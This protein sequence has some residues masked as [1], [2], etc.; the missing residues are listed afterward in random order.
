MGKKQK[1]R[2]NKAQ[3]PKAHK[4][5]KVHSSTEN[6]TSEKQEPTGHSTSLIKKLLSPGVII[7]ILGVTVAVVSIVISICQTKEAEEREI[8]NLR[9][10]LIINPIGLQD[11]DTAFRWEVLLSTMNAGPATV[12]HANTYIALSWPT[13]QVVGLPQVLESPP[14]TKIEIKNAGLPREIS[15]AYENL[16][17]WT[18]FVVRLEFILPDSIRN[19]VK[20]NLGDSDL[21]AHFIQLVSTQGE[22]VKVDYSSMSVQPIP[23]L[24]EL[25]ID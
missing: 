7:G 24:Q 12:E 6:P 25:K 3:E 13:S 4:S 17:P 14:L 21:V 5:E 8:A 18:G 15:Y 23:N 11:D 2:Q 9:H 16:A 19:K 1:R 22:K 10:A 20:F